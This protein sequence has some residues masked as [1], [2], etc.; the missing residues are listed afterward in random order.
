MGWREGEGWM[1][2][3]GMGRVGRWTLMRVVDPEC[4]WSVIVHLTSGF[5]AYCPC[6]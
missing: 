1:G 4:G 5:A 6:Q 3:G 2:K